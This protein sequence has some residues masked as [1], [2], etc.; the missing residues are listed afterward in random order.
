MTK[1]FTVYNICHGQFAYKPHWNDENWKIVVKFDTFT[2]N[3]KGEVSY[4]E[5][6][7]REFAMG[8]NQSGFKYT[9]QAP[10][11]SGSLKDQLKKY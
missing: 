3:T 4:P 1:Y 10:E 7:S 2:I 5:D 6:H 11:I 9:L 8:M